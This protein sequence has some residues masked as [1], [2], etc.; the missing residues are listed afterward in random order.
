MTVRFTL[1]LMAAASFGLVACGKLNE[2]RRPKYDGVP[3]RVS[4]KAINK[5]ETLADFRVQVADAPR[6][7]A[8][9]L[10]A[11]QHEATRYCITNYGT[12]RFDWT[13]IAVD[14]DGGYALQ[15]D[16]G[17]GLFTGTCTP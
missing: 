4:A 7:P 1:S 6:S 2:D 11:A 5:R 13:N 15:L 3:F 10:E 12:S 17:D 8:G 14:G 16:R 9:A